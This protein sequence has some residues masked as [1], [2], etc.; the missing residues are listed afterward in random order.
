MSV[1]TRPASR[2]MCIMTPRNANHH[3]AKSRSIPISITSSKQTHKVYIVG[4][5]KVIWLGLI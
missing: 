1:C 3:I 4:E 5:Y 2:L